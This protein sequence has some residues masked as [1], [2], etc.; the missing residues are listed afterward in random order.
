MSRVTVDTRQHCTDGSFRF[1]RWRTHTEALSEDTGPEALSTQ[2][3]YFALH[4]F[5]EI[6]KHITGELSANCCRTITMTRYTFPA[7]GYEYAAILAP[8]RDIYPLIR[9]CGSYPDGVVSLACSF[10][11]D[12]PTFQHSL[13]TIPVVHG[14]IRTL[15]ETSVFRD[16]GSEAAARTLVTSC[17]LPREVHAY[18]Q[19]HPATARLPRCCGFP[20]LLSQ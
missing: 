10:S 18:I 15:K 20:A 8:K 6:L 12:L 5:Y 4:V 11:N 19:H 1:C 9:S 2:G 13:S 3:Q 17:G 7:F 14:L 16:K